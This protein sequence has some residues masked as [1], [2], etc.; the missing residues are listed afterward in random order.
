MN[1]KS[2]RILLWDIETSHNIVAVFQ[3]KNQDWI[4]P[5]NILMERYVICA[6]WQ[7]LGEDEVHSVSV[8]DSPKLYA[9]D[10]HNDKHVVSV[11]R[12][13]LN[14]ADA[15]VHHNGNAFDNKFV[16]TRAL[17]HDLSPLPPI[18]H[19]DTL[20]IAKTRFLFNS[21]SLDY[22]GK[23]LGVGGKIDHPQGMWLDI[24]KGGPPARKAIE[25]MVTYNKADVELLKGVFLKLRPYMPDY[26]NRQL[27][28]GDGVCPRCGSKHV[29]SRGMHRS[30]TQE[31]RKFQCQ[32][33]RGWFRA[34]KSS[35]HS[36]TRMLG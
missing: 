18:Q 35:G 29:H 19:I 5:N 33:C 3:L 22:L 20:K 7:W 16:E 4:H 28:G 10:P 34:R 26:I 36:N 17:V 11:L 13:V 12:A 31:Y 1:V 14:Q 25:N 27:Y 24:L 15:I 30:L 9:K 32:K 6:S 2:P 8:L 23:L 21:N